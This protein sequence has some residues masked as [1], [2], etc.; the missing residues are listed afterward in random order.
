[1]KNMFRTLG[2]MGLVLALLVSVSAVAFAAAT[3]DSLPEVL[4]GD[5]QLV[6]IYNQDALTDAQKADMAAARKALAG[7]TQKGSVNRYMFTILKGEDDSM[8]IALP[9]NV[10]PT[11]PMNAMVYENGSWTTLEVKPAESG[12]NAVTISPIVSGPMYVSVGF[13]GDDG[14]QMVKETTD[15]VVESVH[16]EK[17]A[18]KFV[19][20]GNGIIITE[21]PDRFTLGDAE[22]TRFEDAYAALE[23]ATPAGMNPH[24]FVNLSK[25][26][27]NTDTPFELTVDLSE[28]GLN[29]DSAIE[30][31]VYQFGEWANQ[32]CI[33]NGDGTV[34]CTIS[35]WG[36]IAIYMA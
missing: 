5:A 22:R 32:V 31:Q 27:S 26:G 34:S 30:I 2:L 33:N 24:Y 11:D 8:T 35:E 7:N 12:E 19:G 16:R 18:F 6:S 4:E 10:K 29:A 28:D 15:V 3:D 9:E 23:D 20:N 1:M 36:P 13:L 14:V 21:Y 25:G 17:I